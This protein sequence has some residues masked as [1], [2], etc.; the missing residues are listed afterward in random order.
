MIIDFL[1]GN[2]EPAIA[3]LTG[4]ADHPAVK[5][6]HDDAR[7]YLTTSKGNFDIIQMSL[8]DT[9]AAS[10][11]G[12]Y[13]LTENGLYTKEAWNTFLNRLSDRGIFTVSRWY[14]SDGFDE[15]TRIVSMAASVCLDQGLTPPRE[16]IAV[17]SS[18]K[19]ATLVISRK[20]IRGELLKTL[21]NV[22]E[23]YEFE[24]LIA[25]D[26]RASIAQHETL[27]C[28][29]TSH[30]L[31]Q[32]CRNSILDI[33]PATDDR[34]YFFNQLRIST[35]PEFIGRDG[36]FGGTMGNLKATLTLLVAFGIAVLG[37]VLGVFWPLKSVGLPAG[38][39]REPLVASFVYFLGIGLGFMLIE[40]SFVQR[41]SV[42]LGHPS[43]ALALV[44][45]SMVLAS[46]V[47][48]YLADRIPQRWTLALRVFPVLIIAILLVAWLLLPGVFAAAVSASFAV[49]VAA[50]LSF[51]VPSGLAMGLC[52]SLG[53]RL[54]ERFGPSATPWMWGV[55]GAASV[56]GT[57]LAV[58]ISMSFGI[59]CT[60]LVGIACY[61][62]VLLANLRLTRPPVAEVQ[63]RVIVQEEPELMAVGV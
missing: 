40:I 59:S 22:C 38:L 35:L 9:W 12:A 45:A 3:K 54:V 39:R 24:L 6:V 53:M 46:G 26:R 28:A 51:T 61:V 2:C 21:Q 33:T 47:G 56:A 30:E 13:S 60:L 7:S 19:V 48:S 57:I 16:H 14:Q 15:T 1:K 18:G 55:N 63:P 44:I 17:A 5:L 25:P 4:L 62:V 11:A 8:I 20:P 58:L 41:F 36:D 43:Y 49:R 10:S 23:S 32:V 42:L 27:L 34:P 37:V 50:T 52:F 31:N 29:T